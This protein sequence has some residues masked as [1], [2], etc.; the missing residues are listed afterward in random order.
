MVARDFLW[1]VCCFFEDHALLLTVAC[2]LF[3]S[4]EPI[5]SLLYLISI[6]MQR[7]VPLEYA[8]IFL[9]LVF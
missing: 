8:N 1:G 5:I 7:K 3:F 2:V 6:Q 4:I 9:P